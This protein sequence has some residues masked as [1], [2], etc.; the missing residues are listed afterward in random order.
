MGNR[1]TVAD[2]GGDQVCVWDV[3]L[4][5]SEFEVV[6]SHS[7]RTNFKMQGMMK[8]KPKN[9]KRGVAT[10]TWAE[11]HYVSQTSPS[12]MPPYST[13]QTAAHNI[14]DAVDVA[15]DGDTVLVEPGD[16]GVTNQITV[17]NAVR[18]LSTG[19]ASQ[20]FL[21]GFLS[22]Y[23]GWCLVISNALAVAD[24]FPDSVQKKWFWGQGITLANSQPSAGTGDLILE[25]SKDLT[26]AESWAATEATI[27]DDG[28][29]KIVTIPA[30]NS[31][32]FFW[33]C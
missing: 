11:T 30:T 4:H 23:G 31:A 20:T 15:S 14:H 25:V 18:L 10:T 19:G 24:G 7:K 12:P 8:I 28:T 29:N 6:N 33:L 22:G 21:T 26:T 13:P 9:R 32:Q 3:E 1:F 27:N 17:T 5:S 2:T 16:Y